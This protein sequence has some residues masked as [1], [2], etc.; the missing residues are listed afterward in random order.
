MLVVIPKAADACLAQSAS[1]AMAKDLKNIM[2]NV[3]CREPSRVP[4]ETIKGRQAAYYS[5][6]ALLFLHVE[7]LHVGRWRFGSELKLRS[8]MNLPIVP[9]MRDVSGSLAAG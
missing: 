2:S 3:Y 5:R 8:C 6:R 4:Q 1:E 7:T 9:P